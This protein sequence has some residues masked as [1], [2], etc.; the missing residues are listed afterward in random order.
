MGPLSGGG[1]RYGGTVAVC[2]YSTGQYYSIVQYQSS[3]TVQHS[4]RKWTFGCSKGNG[5][6]VESRSYPVQFFAFLEAFFCYR[7]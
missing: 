5:T 4:V 7:L 6:A 1:V 2:L 3:P